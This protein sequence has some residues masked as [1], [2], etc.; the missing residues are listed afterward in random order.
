MIRAEAETCFPHENENKLSN[1]TLVSADY[2]FSAHRGRNHPNHNKE[3]IISIS[4]KEIIVFN[5]E[6]KALYI[7]PEGRKVVQMDWHC[8]V[9][10]IFPRLSLHLNVHYNFLSS[11]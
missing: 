4:R 3:E 9:S 11:I 5:F 1:L 6:S 10:V 8:C 2:K 7:P